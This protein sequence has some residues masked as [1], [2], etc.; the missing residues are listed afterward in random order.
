MN[1]SQQKKKHIRK[2]DDIKAGHRW[3]DVPTVL[4]LMHSGTAIVI[5]WHHTY[6]VYHFKAAMSRN[7]EVDAKTHSPVPL[8][9][10]YRLNIKMDGTAAFHATMEKWSP[11]FTDMGTVT[12]LHWQVTESPHR[13]GSDRVLTEI[14]HYSCQS[15]VFRT[16]IIC[17]V[18]TFLKKK[19][20]TEPRGAAEV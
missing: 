20:K 3:K 2:R 7:Q 15:T 9:P 18:F 17:Q 10:E 13:D 5:C 8:C 16:T 4:V 12:S 19:M 1:I 11:N 14:G 6:M